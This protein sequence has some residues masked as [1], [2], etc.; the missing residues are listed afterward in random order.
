M[1]STDTIMRDWSIDLETLDTKPTSAILSIGAVQFDRDSGKIGIRYYASI[2]PDEAIAAGTV[3]GGTLTWW[4]QQSDK[5]KQVFSEKG[6]VPLGGHGGAL[7]TLASHLRSTPGPRVWGDGSS[8]DIAILEHA[9]A[10]VGGALEIPWK[11]WDI[12]DMRT[13]VD[14]A[15]I[16]LGLVPRAGT[17]HNAVDDAEFQAIC[18]SLARRRIRAAMGF[19]L[20]SW[21]GPAGYEGVNLSMKSTNGLP[22]TESPTTPTDDDEEL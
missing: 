5:A 19:G 2:N 17:H 9:F 1:K 13:T 22:F 3:S 18:V 15:G 20:P 12:R 21:Q 6:K 10:R 4:M 7:A 8:F 11:F 16:D 14:D